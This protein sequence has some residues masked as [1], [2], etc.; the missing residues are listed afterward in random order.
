MRF[1]EGGAWIGEEGYRHSKPVEIRD[2]I[3]ISVNKGALRKRRAH[4]WLRK[5]EG[6]LEPV[7]SFDAK[8]LLTADLTG[9]TLR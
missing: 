7:C 3:V 8:K 6:E 5:T 1:I 4:V 9:E 2:N